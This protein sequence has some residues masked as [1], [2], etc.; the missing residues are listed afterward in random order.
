MRTNSRIQTNAFDDGLSIEAFH[1]R[2][3]VQLIEEG[4]TEGQ[5]GVSEK[6]H[7]FGLGCAHKKYWHI[8]LDSAF[9]DD[10]GECVGGFFGVKHYYD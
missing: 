10:R 2:I 5:V 6:L 8:L 1:L 7:S 3:Y 9:F 4:D